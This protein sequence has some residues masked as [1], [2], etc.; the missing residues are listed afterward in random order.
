MQHHHRSKIV[1][2]VN[3]TM[4]SLLLDN[5]FECDAAEELISLLTKRRVLLF[6]WR[7]GVYRWI[8]FHL[9]D[10]GQTR[11]SSLE[12]MINTWHLPREARRIRFTY[13][14]WRS[15]PLLIRIDASLSMIILVV[16]SHL[17]VWK[18]Q[19]VHVKSSKDCQVMKVNRAENPRQVSV[20]I[21]GRVRRTI[22]IAS[23]TAHD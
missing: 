6:E 23:L 11:K 4:F 8:E 12:N 14:V 19:R 9:T 22:F 10:D 21:S 20:D 18:N 17:S 1:A 7:N 2:T 15:S 5:C 3:R 13:S 16:E